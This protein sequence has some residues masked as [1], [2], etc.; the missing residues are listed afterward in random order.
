LTLSNGFNRLFQNALIQHQKA[1]RNRG[2]SM[3]LISV[4]E[5]ARMLG[6]SRTP[7][8]KAIKSGAISTLKDEL[9][10][11]VIDTSELFR[12]FGAPPSTDD[13]N[14][15]NNGGNKPKI[16]STQAENSPEIMTLLAVEREK[17]ALLASTVEA[18]QADKEDLR[19]ERDRLLG[20]VESQSEQVRLL[21]DQ[22]EK[23]QAVALA[24]P[25][26]RRWWWPWS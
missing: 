20:L 22:R 8:Y 13:R 12:V 4:S 3:A 1:F 11:T 9:G 25:T 18:L 24:S 19:R 15:E 14:N 10:K 23:A 2:R 5:A 26:M 17:S 6:Q 16:K 7:L 21:T